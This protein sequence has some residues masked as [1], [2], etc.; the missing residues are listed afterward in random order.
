MFAPTTKSAVDT[1][2][3][4]LF[5]QKRVA[6]VGKV[7][8]TVIGL[9]Y[10][11]TVTMWLA[12]DQPQHL[13]RPAMVLGTIVVG[14]SLAMWLLCRGQPRSRRYVET[15][16]TVVLLTATVDMVLMGR[17]LNL[18][19][20]DAVSEDGS[21]QWV[22][23]PL[24]PQ[25]AMLVQQ[26]AVACLMLGFMFPFA[27]RAALVPST[28]RRTCLLTFMAVVPLFLVSAMGIVP[29]EADQA[30]RDAT[31]SSHRWILATRVVV[32]WTMITA[33][34]TAISKTVHNLRREVK[35]A[36]QLGQYTLELKL[37]EGGMG[38]VYRARH[39]LMRRPTAIKLL[40]PDKAGESS[41]AR[42]EREVQLTAQLTHPNTITIFDYGRTPDGVLYYAME[43]LDGA[44]LEAVVELDGAQPPARVVRLLAMVAGA[45]D[46][47]HGIGL[48][49][50]DIKPANI[51]L[52]EQG[53]DLDV[54]KVLDFGLVKA[55]R[56]P[57]DSSLTQDGAITGTPLY[58]PPEALINP[59][60][61]DARSDLYSVGAVGY[62]LLTGS[63]VFD[64]ESV[65]E[66]C[67]HHLHSAPVPPSER[68]AEPVPTDLE[69]VILRCLEKDAG[70][71]PQSA[72]E[73]QE[74]L[75]ACADVGNW[76]REQAER[77]WADHGDALKPSR[78]LATADAASRTL[79]IDL[80][81]G[82]A[83]P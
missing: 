63:H 76:S 67:G 75:L 33:V 19:L 51:I 73:L 26:D 74:Q 11:F 65:V 20:L 80:A 2:E 42:F 8:T 66:I 13:Y 3:G 15:V 29:L 48:I 61:V 62:Y 58:M 39:A 79:A 60:D 71:R 17:Y 55:M 81:K 57:A 21:A 45:L 27:L 54:A 52:C 40:P 35:Q 47:A 23:E 28:V 83:A 16:E 37:G 64:G 22:G 36:M 49:H 69:A 4:T 41:L 72:R 12:Q 46:E 70:E 59:D 18:L 7:L 77:W 24:F 82:R 1:P 30:I 9:G 6:L 34:C 50:R 56:E 5:L 32:W 10:V 44:T 43:L 38:E 68:L 14:C 25:L 53:G 31:P 78:Q